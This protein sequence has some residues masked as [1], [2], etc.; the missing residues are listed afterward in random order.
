MR[1][2]PI[3]FHGWQI[4]SLQIAG[5]LFPPLGK[6]EGETKTSCQEKIKGVRHDLVMKAADSCWSKER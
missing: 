5:F 2:D 1:S 4:K 3:D 6:V